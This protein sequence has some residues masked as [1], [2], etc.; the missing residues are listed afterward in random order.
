MDNILRVLEHLSYVLECCLIDFRG[1]AKHEL[2]KLV[3]SLR[4]D[5]RYRI[6]GGEVI[7]NRL[8]VTMKNLSAKGFEDAHRVFGEL[9]SVARTLWGRIINTQGNVVIEIADRL[10]Q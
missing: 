3:V 6:Q 4:C 9:S 7:A 2:G 5:E 1:E 10:Q 8:E